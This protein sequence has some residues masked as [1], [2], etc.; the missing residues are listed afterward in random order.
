MNDEDEL[1]SFHCH[2]IL[3]DDETHEERKRLKKVVAAADDDARVAWTVHSEKVAEFHYYLH[4]HF[5]HW[6]SSTA[7]FLRAKVRMQQKES[8]CKAGVGLSLQMM[9]TNIFL[10][11]CGRMMKICLTLKKSF[12]HLILLLLL[13]KSDDGGDDDDVGVAVGILEVKRP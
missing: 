1:I 3:A 10:K 6:K 13:E 7:H 9:R 8:T 11:I 12:R 5:L 4:T 2:L